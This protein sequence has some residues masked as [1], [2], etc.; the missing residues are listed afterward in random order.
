ML[1]RLGP[2]TRL[3]LARAPLAPLAARPAAV[4]A[5]A[6]STLPRPAIKSQQRPQQQQQQ[7]HASTG[8]GIGGGLR[9]SHLFIALAGGAILITT[10]G[11]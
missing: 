10:Y 5:R 8:A 2:H 1:A 9:V 7:R 11:M 6:L 3:V 4:S